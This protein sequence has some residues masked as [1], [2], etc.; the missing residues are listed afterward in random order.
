M[1]RLS[2]DSDAQQINSTSGFQ[3]ATPKYSISDTDDVQ[4]QPITPEPAFQTGGMCRDNVAGR[5]SMEPS[6]VSKGGM[7]LDSLMHHSHHLQ[8]EHDLTSL[9]SQ[10]SR[11]SW[12]RSYCRHSSCLAAKPSQTCRPR[13]R[14]RVNECPSFTKGLQAWKVWPP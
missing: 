11:T 7:D 4:F 12:R 5:L 9:K 1:H 8:H 3:P 14:L 13:S 10:T 2:I 6:F